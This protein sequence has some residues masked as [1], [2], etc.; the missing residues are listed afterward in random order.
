MGAEFNGRTYDH[1]PTQQE[2]DDLVE[3]AAYEHGHDGYTGSW[4]EAAGGLRFTGRHFED[5]DQAREYLLDN[6]PKWE[7]AWVVSFGAD[8]D[9][10]WAIGAWCSS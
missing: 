1:K 4:A 3:Q 5:A 7:A 2:Y 8:E 6:A 9:K 10:R